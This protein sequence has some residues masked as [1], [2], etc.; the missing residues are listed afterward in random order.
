MPL[1]STGDVDL[2]VLDDALERLA[3]L[4]PQQARIVEVRYFGGLTIDEVAEVTQISRATVVREWTVAK[5][6]LRTQLS[7]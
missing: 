5:A 2:V 4:D 7:G 6:W 1:G 3:E